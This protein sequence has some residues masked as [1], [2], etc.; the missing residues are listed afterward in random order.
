MWPGF[1]LKP[2]FITADLIFDPDRFQILAYFK[3]TVIRIYQVFHTAMLPKELTKIHSTI[4]PR[5]AFKNLP[6]ANVDLP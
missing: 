5:G 2:V 1:Q 3:P 6:L 4:Y